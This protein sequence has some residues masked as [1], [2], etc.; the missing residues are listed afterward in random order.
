MLISIQ[1]RNLVEKRGFRT[2]IPNSKSL[3][4]NI[5]CYNKASY[6]VKITKNQSHG[7]MNKYLIRNSVLPGL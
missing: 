2:F 3:T 4:F 6:L 7:D 1:K 5:S